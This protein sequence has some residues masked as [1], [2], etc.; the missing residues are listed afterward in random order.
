MRICCKLCFA[1]GRCGCM[2]LYFS[3]LFYVFNQFLGI[4]MKTRN[5][6]NRLVPSGRKAFEFP[7]PVPGASL[8]TPTPLQLMVNVLSATLFLSGIYK[9]KMKIGNWSPQRKQLNVAVFCTAIGVSSTRRGVLNWGSCLGKH[10]WHC[11]TSPVEWHYWLY[12][13][14]L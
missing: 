13:K 8:Y 12:H 14:V 6:K 10:F 1:S 4:S 5:A 9:L 2:Y 11:R 3:P 7:L